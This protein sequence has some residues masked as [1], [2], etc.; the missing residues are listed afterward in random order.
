MSRNLGA[1]N[2]WN[3]VGLFR[4]VMGQLYLYLIYI[5]SFPP[6]SPSYFLLNPLQISSQTATMKYKKYWGGA[7]TPPPKFMPMAVHYSEESGNPILKSFFCSPVSTQ[8]LWS[9]GLLSKMWERNS[10]G[11]YILAIFRREYNDNTNVMNLEFRFPRRW[12]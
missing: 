10:I 1:L 11:L 8:A 4:P 5:H 9:S 7:L 6:L 2:F 12:L 3:P